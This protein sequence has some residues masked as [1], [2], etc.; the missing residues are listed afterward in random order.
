MIVINIDPVAFSL[1]PIAVRWYGI[2]YAVGIT[3]GL[4]VAWPYAKFRGITEDQMWNVVWI[5][6]PSG[7]VGARLY[8]VLQQ[9]LGQYLREPWR[10]A[11]VWEGGMAFYGAIFAVVLAVAIT[12]WQIKVSVWKFLDVAVLF[13][14]VG[15][16]FGRIG[17]V[18]NGDVIGY[19]TTLPWG[20]VYANPN[21]FAPRH[22]IAYQPAAVYEGIIN[23]ILFSIL[24]SLRKKVRPGM[25]FFVYIF[26]YS[27]AQIIVFIWRDNEVVLLGLKQAQL[28]AA[29]VIVVAAAVF[30]WYLKRQSSKPSVG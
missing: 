4:L 17:N 19:P 15:Q 2:M 5:A 8:Y 1:G 25:L 3:V 10:I 24:W 29:A 23:I 28:T 14:A 16:F 18:I 20:F 21:S 13:G 27:L 11:A 7:L 6:V 26:S 12:T 30:A 9:P 22:D